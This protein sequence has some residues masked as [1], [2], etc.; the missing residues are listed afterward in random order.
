M[1][2]HNCH[3]PLSDPESV[4]Q[5]IGPICREKL[6]FQLSLFKGAAVNDAGPIEVIGLVCVRMP[7]GTPSTNIPQRY[8]YHSPGGFEWG[9]SGSGPA[10]L[11]LNVLAHFLPIDETTQIHRIA[12]G[13]VTDT[14]WTLH[15]AFKRDFLEGMPEEGGHL[16]AEEIKAWIEEHLSKL[17]QIDETTG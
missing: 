16:P 10:D 2:C 4:R 14:A 5:G 9:Y 15:Q 13:I 12:L 6:S 17:K 1:N 3:R 11:A 8:S 7:D